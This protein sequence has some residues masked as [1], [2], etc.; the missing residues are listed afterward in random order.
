MSRPPKP[1]LFLEQANYRQRRLRDAIR[2]LPILGAILFAIPLL[3]ETG[4]GAR[5]MIYV[6]LIWFGLIVLAAG[7]SFFLRDDPAQDAG[8][9]DEWSR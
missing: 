7:L 5:A 4:V 6:F 9:A 3:W 1:G 8:K 2:L